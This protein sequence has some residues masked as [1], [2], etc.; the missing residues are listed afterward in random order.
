MSQYIDTNICTVSTTSQHDVEAWKKERLGYFTATRW[1]TL[2]L[3]C[4]TDEQKRAFARKIC[5]IDKDE[6]PP[7][8]MKYVKYGLDNEDKVRKILESITGRTIHELG[9]IKSKVYEMFACSVDGVFECDLNTNNP[10]YEIAEFKTTKKESPTESYPDFREIDIGYYWQ[11]Q[12]N[13]VLTGAKKCHFFSYSYT[14]NLIYY[15][16]VPFN[17]EVWKYLK[18]I[19][20]DFC[21]NYIDPIYDRVTKV[22]KI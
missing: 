6:I 2:I 8:N 17:E 3:Y 10:E 21:H 13:M 9:L 7:E 16:V 19:G 18:P 14:S 1:K 4:K 5:G 12:H 20:I 11:M 22:T 15:R